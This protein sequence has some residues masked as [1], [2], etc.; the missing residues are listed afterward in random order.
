MG[1]QPSDP[2]RG[3]G[4]GGIAEHQVPLGLLAWEKGTFCLLRLDLA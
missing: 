3:A 2:A 4:A 1:S